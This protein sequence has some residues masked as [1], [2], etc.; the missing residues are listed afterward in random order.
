MDETEQFISFEELETRKY[1]IR[2]NRIQSLMNDIKIN[3]KTHKH[4]FMA[5]RYNHGYLGDLGHVEVLLQEIDRFLDK[6]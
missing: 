6:D 3:L 1:T 5:D 2:S 4:H